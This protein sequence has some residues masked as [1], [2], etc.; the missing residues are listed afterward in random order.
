MCF[1]LGS[2][3]F[4]CM[5]LQNVLQNFTAVDFGVH[6]KVTNGKQSH[7]LVCVCVCV[8]YTVCLN[9]ELTLWFEG[10]VDDAKKL[11]VSQLSFG[12]WRIAVL[13][14]CCV[15]CFHVDTSVRDAKADCVY[16]IIVTAFTPLFI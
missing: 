12:D 1:I 9:R 8:L 11:H 14:F 4:F 13:Q 7:M 16:I 3:G 10:C 15:L 2:N 6:A 5:E